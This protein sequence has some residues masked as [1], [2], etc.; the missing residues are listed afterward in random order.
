MPRL[1][2]FIRKSL[3]EHIAESTVPTDLRGNPNL[4]TAIKLKIEEGKEIAWRLVRD[5]DVVSAENLGP[6]NGPRGQL[7]TRPS[8][9]SMTAPSTLASTRF[10]SYGPIASPFGGMSE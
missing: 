2:A 4:S 5:A 7:A 9:R 8:R 10:G 6:R 1:A 3:S